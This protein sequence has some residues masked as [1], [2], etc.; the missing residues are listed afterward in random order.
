MG[1]ELVLLSLGS[2]AQESSW[3]SDQ[4]LCLRESQESTKDGR[5]HTAASAKRLQG[6]KSATPVSL[7][8]SRQWGINTFRQTQGSTDNSLKMYFLQGYR[9]GQ[10]H[11]ATINCTQGIELVSIR[12]WYYYSEYI[13]PL[14]FFHVVDKEVNSV[15]WC[16]HKDWSNEWNMALYQ[17]HAPRAVVFSSWWD[18]HTIF[19]LWFELCCLLSVLSS[20]L[21]YWRVDHCWGFAL[22]QV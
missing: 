5:L 6:D 4:L 20:R 9:E 19:S 11:L 12:V 10:A 21:E 15:V 13:I 22:G 1:K 8:K 17:S 7:D 16:D 18:N 14:S 3:C 2:N